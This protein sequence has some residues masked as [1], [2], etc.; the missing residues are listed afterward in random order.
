MSDIEKAMEERALQIAQKLS[1][2]KNDGPDTNNLIPSI[3]T[4]RKQNTRGTNKRDARKKKD[5]PA[6]DSARKLAI[7]DKMEDMVRTLDGLN[8]EISEIDREIENRAAEFIEL[9]HLAENDADYAKTIL[10]VELPSERIYVQLLIGTKLKLAEQYRD[11]GKML[12]F[13]QMKELDERF[14]KINTT[15]DRLSHL[16]ILNRSSH[17]QDE[18]LLNL[19]NELLDLIDGNYK[20]EAMAEA[21]HNA[22]AYIADMSKKNKEEYRKIKKPAANVRE[23]YKNFST[24]IKRYAEGLKTIKK[25][26]QSGKIPILI[27]ALLL[28][29]RADDEIYLALQDY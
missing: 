23:T 5:I 1:L 27:E 21:L 15:N 29:Q 4:K 8:D 18:L 17:H 7:L 26:L 28:T 12:K 20:P 25:N 2:M 6:E 22:E 9:A 13:K 10:P 16:E 11:L 14:E 3:T 24:S 19:R